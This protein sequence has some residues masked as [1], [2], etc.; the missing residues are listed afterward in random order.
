MDISGCQF[1]DCLFQNGLNK[2]EV[3]SVRNVANI[4]YFYQLKLQTCKIKAGVGVQ[5]HQIDTH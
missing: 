3:L 2:F 4:T 1:G 5:Y